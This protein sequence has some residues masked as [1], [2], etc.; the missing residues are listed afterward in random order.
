MYMYQCMLLV[1]KKQE[2]VITMYAIYAYMLI[3]FWRFEIEYLP[4]SYYRCY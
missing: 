1:K 4:V 2:S 3:F